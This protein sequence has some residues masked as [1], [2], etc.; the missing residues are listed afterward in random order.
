MQAPP[1]AV[2]RGDPVG[3][4]RA[5]LERYGRIP[6]PRYTSYPPANHW[7]SMFGE[8]EAREAFCSAGT[9]AASI[10]VHV[11]FCRKLCYYCG[12]NMLVTRSESLVERYLRALE[13]ELDRVTALLSARPEIVQVHLGGGTP[14]YLDP[15]QLARLADAIQA[16]LP[17]SPGIEASIEIHPAV[18]SVEQIRTLAR[19]GFN[20][21]SMGV[22]DFDPTVQKRINRRQSFEETRDLVL[23]A[24][25]RGFVSVN[26][27]L[28][29]GL[30]LQTVEHFQRTLD[31]IEELR[32]DR[33]ALFGYAHVPSMKK[34]QG[35]FRP[36]ELPGTA[37]RL[38]LLESSVQR[39]L[40]AGYVH[41]GLDHFALEDDELCRARA[42][43]T[44]RRNFMGYTTCADS[45]VLAF[46]PSAISE[47]RGTY[48]QNAREVH[49]WAE[50]LEKGRLPA[51]RGHRPSDEDLARGALIMRLF[52]S[53]EVDL[54]ELRARF[55]GTLCDLRHEERDLARLERDGLVLRQ[56]ARIRVT[57]RG[58]LLLRSVAAPFDTYHRADARLHAPAL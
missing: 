6:V 55:P 1:Q 39:L 32:P 53:L 17:W 9:R 23:E 49:D 51:V 4:D 37:E 57:P 41:V 8:L 18:T 46:G 20:R 16:R 31:R 26:V 44:L 50:M 22:Q 48:V 33:I 2:Q 42:A 30:P 52:C 13:L 14:T 34:H 43:G 19:L 54:D 28:M 12:C 58:Q 38:A 15:D 21:V 35:L 36:E 7:E 56:R 25:M 3:I 27:D 10:Y 29:Y 47:V 40:A 5:L 45:D 24:R 11:P